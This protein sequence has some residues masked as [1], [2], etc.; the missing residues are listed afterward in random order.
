M[1]GFVDFLFPLLLFL[2]LDSHFFAGVFF[3][4]VIVP[5]VFSLLIITL[6]FPL[7][8]RRD[9]GGIN[10]K[11]DSGVFLVFFPHHPW[12]RPIA[13]LYQPSFRLIIVG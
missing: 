3:C 2:F 12:D 6:T 7:A 10:T 9:S 5:A 13:S 1:E 11:V 8:S 4:T